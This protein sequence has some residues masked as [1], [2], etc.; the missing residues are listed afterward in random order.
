MLVLAVLVAPACTDAE[1]PPPSTTPRST[2]PG[3][4]PRSTAPRITDDPSASRD[5]SELLTAAEVTEATGLKGVVAQDLA[6]VDAFENPDPRGPCGARVPPKPTAGGFGRA[7][8]A[9]DVVMV[10]MV[11][12]VMPTTAA[13][14]ASI[15][16]DKADARPSC[17][18]YTSRTANGDVQHV[19]DVE[20]LDMP[21]GCT[22]C[23]GW[24]SKV[25]VRD[26]TAFGLGLFFESGGSTG[27]VQVVSAERVPAAVALALLDRARARLHA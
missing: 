18:P 6:D 5:A 8:R 14:R 12:M 7:F 19:S 17:G 13:T 25:S 27:F 22:R 10:V 20:I 26:Q 16:A 15:D 11:E 21:A 2:D 4:P 3:E 24:T 1:E 9:G 23:V